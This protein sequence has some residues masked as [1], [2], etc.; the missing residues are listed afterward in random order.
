M[1]KAVD[2]SLEN[3]FAQSEKLLDGVTAVQIGSALGPRTEIYCGIDY[4]VEQKLQWIRD[5]NIEPVFQLNKNE[6]AEVIVKGVIFP[7][8]YIEICHLSYIVPRRMTRVRFK[9]D[10]IKGKVIFELPM[11]DRST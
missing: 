1:E 10:K 8:A 9:L 4:S 6:T 3:P 11:N 2:Y 5:K 7:S